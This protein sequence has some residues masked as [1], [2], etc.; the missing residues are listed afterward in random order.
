MDDYRRKKTNECQAYLEKVTKW[1]TFVL[2]AR[3]GMRVQAGADSVKWLK[4][5]KNWV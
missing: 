4:N 5:K 2:D 1:E 3:I